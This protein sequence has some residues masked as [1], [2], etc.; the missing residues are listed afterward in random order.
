[1]SVHVP[2]CAL[3]R[4]ACAEA[5]AHTCAEASAHAHTYAEAH[6][7]A[8]VHAPVHARACMRATVTEYARYPASLRATEPALNAADRRK[9]RG[10]SIEWSTHAQPEV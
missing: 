1:M 3:A 4:S 10:A 8:C 6:A 2:M 7:H 9:S 5:R